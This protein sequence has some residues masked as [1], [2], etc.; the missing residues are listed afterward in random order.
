[1]TV[2]AGGRSQ[3]RE[4]HT[5]GVETQLHFGLGEAT[6]VDAIEVRWPSGLVQVVEPPETAMDGPFTITEP[7][8]CLEAP[9]APECAGVHVAARPDPGRRPGRQDTCKPTG[10]PIE[11]E[12]P[13]AMREG[14]KTIRFPP[15]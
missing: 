1:V 13:G 7:A 11:L 9:D 3:V 12:S 4:L 15:Y 5:G 14:P 2:T 10:R 6:R 8:V